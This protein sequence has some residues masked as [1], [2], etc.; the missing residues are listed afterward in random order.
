MSAKELWR[1]IH[2]LQPLDMVSG[3]RGIRVP[4]H[5]GHW[6]PL[7]PEPL[8]SPSL[9]PNKEPIWEEAGS[10]SR[11][12]DTCKRLTHLG[13]G[14]QVLKLQEANFS[15]KP[16]R[17]WGQIGFLLLLLVRNSPPPPLGMTQLSITSSQISV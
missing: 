10:Y 2:A 11:V 9:A 12:S 4:Q 7:P 14:L 8:H 17:T 5:G 15:S 1:N 16:K 6:C 13:E 3:L